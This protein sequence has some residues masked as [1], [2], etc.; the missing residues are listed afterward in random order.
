MVQLK[1]A[2]S[3][4]TEVCGG[5]VSVV[6]SAHHINKADLCPGSNSDD[7]VSEDFVKILD[8]EVKTYLSIDAMDCEDEGKSFQLSFKSYL[9]PLRQQMTLQIHHN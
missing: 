3:L 4:I 9:V 1:S 7:H 2:A 8:E 6:D 5:S